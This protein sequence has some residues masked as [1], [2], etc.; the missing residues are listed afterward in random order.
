MPDDP[1]PVILD[2]P[3]QRKAFL[4]ET[5][6]PEGFYILSAQEIFAIERGSSKLQGVVR[7]WQVLAQATF[8]VN[9]P[10]EA[11]E[12]VKR[13]NVHR[14]GIFDDRMRYRNALV[15]IMNKCKVGG[16]FPHLP[17]WTIARNAINNVKEEGT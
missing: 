17:S 12:V 2:T 7:N 8:G 3:E 11:L 5:R 15:N 9:T 6:A 4:K 13:Q 16:A 10:E 1:A 14:Q